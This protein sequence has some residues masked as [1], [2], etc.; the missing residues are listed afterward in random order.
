M[1]LSFENYIIYPLSELML[2]HFVHLLFRE[3]KIKKCVGIT[4][5]KDINLQSSDFT[6]LSSVIEE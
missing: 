4:L 2:V 5:Q 6:A 1:D 3:N